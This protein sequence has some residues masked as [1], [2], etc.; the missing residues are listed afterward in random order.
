VLDVQEVTVRFG[1]K[2]ALSNTSITVEPGKVTG[3]IGPNGAGKT[4]LFNVV[5]G[6]LAPNAGKVLLDGRNITNTAPHRRARLGL[7]RTFQRL[8]LFT[9]LTVRDNVRVAADIRRRWAARA[10]KAVTRT[11]DDGLDDTDRILEPTGLTAIADREVSEIPTG[12]ARVVE[13]ARALMTQPS[14]LLLDEPAAGQT[15]AETAEFGALLRRL[16][17][18]GMA[19]CLVEHDMTLVMDVCETIHV[20]DYG[21]TIAVGA[22]GEIRNDPAVVD[23]YLGTPEGVA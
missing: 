18:D 6:L 12:Q 11:D 17:G 13:L 10:A 23:A 9:S 16:A 4:T 19:V 15:E 2:A 5:T 22:P 14:V 20:L 21:R 3:L 8:E 1:G 7:A